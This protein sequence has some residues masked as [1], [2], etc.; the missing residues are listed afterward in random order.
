MGSELILAFLA[1]LILGLVYFRSIFGPFN[2]TEGAMF[3][4]L[5]DGRS[6]ALINR[7]VMLVGLKYAIGFVC[8]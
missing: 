1:K 6:D 5:T 7:L 8:L 3:I 2:Y 4:V